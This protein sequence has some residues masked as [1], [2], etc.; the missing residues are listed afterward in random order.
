MC[1]EADGTWLQQRPD[2]GAEGMKAAR[3]VA[4][5]SYRH[6]ST[7]AQ[8]QSILSGD[9]ELDNSDGRTGAESYQRYQGN[10]LAQRFN[11]FS[12]YRLSQGMDGHNVGRGRGGVENAL[13]Q[14]TAKAMVIG[15]S[16]DI[17]FPPVEQEFVAKQIAGARYKLIHSQFGHDGFLLESWQIE[18]C[19][20][21]LLVYGAAQPAYCVSSF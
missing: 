2:A 19:L 10:K 15:I 3:S 13:R 9:L 21:E 1:I 12:Y 16:S 6:Y 11:A 8:T 20:V 17:L 18:N 5:L 14:V 7:Y 4:L